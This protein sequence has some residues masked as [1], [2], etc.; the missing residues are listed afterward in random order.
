VAPGR[1]LVGW[2]QPDVRSWRSTNTWEEIRAALA[3]NRDALQLLSEL[4]NKAAFDFEIDY[5]RLLFHPMP[6]RSQLRRAATLLSASAVADLQADDPT[7][8][9]SR[10]LSILMLARASENERH[11]I[12][13]LVRIANVATAM[14][15]SWEL[16]QAP[17]LRDEQ[18]RALQEA[19]MDL[20]FI[21][22]AEA[23]LCMERAASV[24]IIASCRKR[25]TSV[26]RM[27]Y[28]IDALED[29]PAE[30]ASSAKRAW[31]AVR[32]KVR[33]DLRRFWWSY[34]DEMRMLQVSQVMIDTVR[35]AEKEGCFGPAL[36]EQ[37][38]R[39]QALNV[40]SFENADLHQ[41]ELF[42]RS[43]MASEKV[44]ER[45]MTIESARALTVTAIALERFHLNHG[46]YPQ[47]LSALVPEFL[48]SVPRDPVDGQPLRYRR[49]DDGAFLLYSVGEDGVDNGGDPHPEKS[50]SSAWRSGRDWVW[51][52]RAT[53]AEIAEWRS[54][55]GGR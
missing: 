55:K 32:R 45:V 15:A 17:G 33:D 28:L 2:A 21:H 53:E 20:E 6:D 23:A 18:L 50:G 1:A 12:A 5:P 7:S 34:R 44:P 24:G 19:W 4:P 16:L 46:E 37:R 35:Q 47:N 40:G 36:A 49:D 51:P 43:A 14:S 41:L 54:G 22:A 25:N 3:D 10:I 38:Q 39:L 27:M 26:R 13:Q 29:A 31:R 9:A 8:A 42:A 48:T 52:R 30:G 11:V